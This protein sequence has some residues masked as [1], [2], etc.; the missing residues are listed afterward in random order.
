MF[1]VL[2]TRFSWVFYFV[3]SIN[4]VYTSIPVS[5]SGINPFSGKGPGSEGVSELG[6]L[7]LAAGVHQ[8]GPGMEHLA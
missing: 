4:S 8:T 2:Y 6:K 5:P 1:P 7:G 3:H